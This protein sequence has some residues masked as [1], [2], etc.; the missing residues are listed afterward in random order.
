MEHSLVATRKLNVGSGAFKK[1][2]YLN[3]DV[4]ARFNPDILHDLD[5]IP[6]PFKENAFSL[7]EADHVL[8]HLK[9]PF[10]TIREMH[11]LT[12][13]GGHI[14]IRVPHFS[15]G[16]SHPDHKCGFDV[17]LPYYFDRAF[18]ARYVND[19]VMETVSM[20]LHWFAQPYVKKLALSQMQF[21]LG[22]AAG[23]L[24]D[25]FANI[26]PMFCSRIWCFWVGGFDEI[27]Y[28]FKVVK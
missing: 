21:Y 9:H 18:A 4:D 19:I 27:E 1:E 20:K 2:G 24:I 3:V 22:Y 5:R 7:I 16:F 13:Q 14:V 28:V 17:S 6:Y 12:E 10:E 26:S 8:E 11:R 25:F 23:K 15:R